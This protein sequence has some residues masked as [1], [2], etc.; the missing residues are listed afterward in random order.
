M[1]DR[2]DSFRSLNLL[3]FEQHFVSEHLA[4]GISSVG[5]AS[6]WQ[7]EGQGFESPILHFNFLTNEDFHTSMKTS[8][9]KGTAGC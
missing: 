3:V 5:R 1:G 4:R 7:P 6:G 2:F 9:L 8:Q